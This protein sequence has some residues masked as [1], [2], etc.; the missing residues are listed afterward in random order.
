MTVTFAVILGMLVNS[1]YPFYINDA[2]VCSNSRLVL[3]LHADDTFG[4]TGIK[5]FLL[6]ILCGYT[7]YR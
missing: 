5:Y 3:Y 1:M 4:K 2:F 6:D 7:E